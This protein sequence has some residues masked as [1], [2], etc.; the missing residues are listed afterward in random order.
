MGVGPA[1][2]DK[3]MEGCADL[4]PEEGVIHP[5]LRFVDVFFGR[6][7]VVI[8]GQDHGFAGCE[9]I[10]CVSR[11]SLEPIH[12]VVE[13]WTGGGVAIWQVKAADCDTIDCRLDIT[14][15]TIFG[16]ARE[17]SP[18]LL[19]LSAACQDGDTVPTLLAMPDGFITRVCDGLFREFFLGCH[20]FL[21]AGGVW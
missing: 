16:V 3:R 15:V 4:G 8:P 1:L 9:E 10:G 7:D 18:E 12:F 6:H 5:F 14:A 20:G 19:W 17:D 11:E 2:C 13:F 21:Q